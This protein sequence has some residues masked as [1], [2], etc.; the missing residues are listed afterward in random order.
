MD[1]KNNK[2]EN[3]NESTTVTPRQALIYAALVGW[4]GDEPSPWFC[5][6]AIDDIL[7]WA[8][9]HFQGTKESLITAFKELETEG[10]FFEI[11]KGVFDPPC[12]FCSYKTHFL[13]EISDGKANIDYW[14]GV[15]EDYDEKYGLKTWR[16]MGLCAGQ[17]SQGPSDAP[18]GPCLGYSCC[19]FEEGDKKCNHELLFSPN[20]TVICDGCGK[21]TLREN[22]KNFSSGLVCDDGYIFCQP[23][24]C[25]DCT[26]SLSAL[27]RL[28]KIWSGNIDEKRS[29]EEFKKK[30]VEDHE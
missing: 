16:T 21:E 11:H 23:K 10:L 19:W 29:R 26:N 24:V 14:D 28:C 3:Q 25:P 6:V 13:N 4:K 27:K 8:K 15:S 2:P 1:I 22:L 30:Q 18:W 9:S 17:G 7:A 20:K 5:P 12:Y